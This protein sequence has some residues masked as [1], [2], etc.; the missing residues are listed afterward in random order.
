MTAVDVHLS[1]PSPGSAGG[2]RLLERYF[3]LFMALLI[4]ATVVYGFSFTIDRNLIHPAI[5]RPRILYVHAVVFSAWLVFFLLQSILVRS[6]RVSWHR[7]LGWFGAGLGAL[8]PLVG[9]ATAIAM[10]HFNLT[11]LHQS[12]VE[13]DLMIP[14]WDMVAFTPAFASAI[15]WRKKPEVHRRLI[16]VATCV[17]TA[18]AF[19]RFPP[20][21]LNPT[22]FYAGVDV[23][24]ALG[25][26][27]DWIVERRIHPVYL[28]A[29]P[30]LM[31][32]QTLVIYTNLHDLRYWLAIAHAILG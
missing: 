16:L 12:H 28:V 13:A 7:R 26:L 30:L 24:V 27:R 22:F 15:V 1:A 10:A 11:Q 19:G 9:T 32:G 8:I 23:L 21:L 5:P 17:L 6:R 3:Y 29:L 14:L 18:A 20:T 25:A 31:L 4:P 2:T